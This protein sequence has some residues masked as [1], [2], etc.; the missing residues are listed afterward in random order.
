MR[1]RRLVP[2]VALLA[3]VGMVYL[4]QRNGPTAPPPAPAPSEGDIPSHD[5]DVPPTL[6][7]ERLMGTYGDPFTDPIDDLRAI[8]R[9]VSGYFSIIKEHEGFSIGGNEDLAACLRGEN[10][11]RQRFLPDNHRA[12]GPGGRLVDR[13]G[14]PVFVHPLAARQFELR[15]AGPDREL[16]TDDDVILAPR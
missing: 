14:T 11:Y 12:F 3:A 5:D 2:L 7:G 13:W 16:F 8:D 9:V 1:A 4:I 10:A 6:P 15:S